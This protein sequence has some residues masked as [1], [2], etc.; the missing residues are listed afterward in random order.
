MK[1]IFSA[2]LI[3]ISLSSASHANGCYDLSRAEPRS[4]T[5]KLD[6]VIFAGPPNFEDVRKG[7]A[8]EPS[9]ILKLESPICVTGDDFADPTKKI[10]AVQL[11]ETKQTAKLLMHY[12]H[13]TVTITLSDQM[14]AE[15]GHHH[16]PLVGTVKAVIPVAQ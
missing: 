10:S 1:S 5:G 3:V 13:K 16:E 8:P 11:V 9:Y 12:L 6:H 7:D 4:L 2:F 15:N 14:A